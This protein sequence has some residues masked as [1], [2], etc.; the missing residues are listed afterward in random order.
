MSD[1]VTIDELFSPLRT[2]YSQGIGPLLTKASY[3]RDK[4]QP[5]I[6]ING[7][8]ISYF[9]GG[10]LATPTESFSTSIA[11]FTPMAG[12]SHI[13]PALGSL[14]LLKQAY[15]GSFTDD[16]WTQQVKDY[17]TVVD[18]ILTSLPSY[19]ASV[20]N[21]LEGLSDRVDEIYAM[22][23]YALE[24]TSDYCTQL[25]ENTDQAIDWDYY[26]T[27]FLES[28]DGKGYNRVMVATFSIILLAIYTHSFN[29]MQA[30]SLTDTDWSNVRV[31]LNGIQGRPSSG[32]VRCNNTSF[33][34]VQA[35][36]Q[37]KSGK[38]K[39]DFQN[40]FI[41]PYSV[42]PDLTSDISKQDALTTID[43][44]TG[45]EVYGLFYDFFQI[46]PHVDLAKGMFKNSPTFEYPNC[47]FGSHYTNDNLPETTYQR[48]WA[49]DYKQNKVF[50]AS[51][52]VAL[53]NYENLLSSSV[54]DWVCDKLAETYDGSFHP[55]K[56]ML[57]G[58]DDVTW[59]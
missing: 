47:D 17:K 5:L 27:T 41:S 57:P 11:G 50:T 22:L 26:H 44:D 3:Q 32:L 18:N 13:G 29:A 58:L 6:V 9:K 36:F 28:A 7:R 37:I 59:S 40:L 30:W 33:R 52:R 15:A 48:P 25:L 20:W 2:G 10:D 31:L 21:E 12:V 34:A 16:E 38:A 53:E 46:Y 19:D 56:V 55:D 35:I 4:A 51:L 14:I 43:A 23:K 24:K 1:N 39:V 8:N 42:Y 54:S 45:A 49:T